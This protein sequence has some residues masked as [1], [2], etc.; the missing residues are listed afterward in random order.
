MSAA[1]WIM[2]HAGFS[3]ARSLDCATAGLAGVCQR[4]SLLAIDTL[5][6]GLLLHAASAATRTS[7]HPPDT[8]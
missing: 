4:A 5:N 2:D 8:H 7:G 1:G 3:T 6:L